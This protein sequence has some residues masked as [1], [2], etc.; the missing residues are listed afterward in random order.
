MAIH[1]PVGIIYY[2]DNVDEYS[3]EAKAIVSMA[4]GKDVAKRPIVREVVREVLVHYF[5][6]LDKAFDGNDGLVS[7]VEAI[8]SHRP[9]QTEKR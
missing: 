1:D 8:L 5:A 2:P 6:D 7:D 4:A 9:Q 3:I